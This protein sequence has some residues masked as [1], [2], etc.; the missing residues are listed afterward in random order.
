MHP[1]G[2]AAGPPAVPRR[3]HGMK[4]DTGT[5]AT[6]DTVAPVPF[7]GSRPSAAGEDHRRHVTGA[8]YSL[9]TKDSSSG[10]PVSGYL[11][12]ELKARGS[13]QVIVVVRAATGTGAAASASEGRRLAGHFSSAPVARSSVLAAS[14][15]VVGAAL[16]VLPAPRGASGTVDRD[17]LAALRSDPQVV[18]VG[19]A[20]ALSPI[21]PP[22][23][24][25][26]RLDTARTWGIERL[27]VPALWDRGPHGAGGPRGA[28]RHGCRR[29]APGPRGG[30]AH[31]AEFDRMGRAVQPPRS[32]TTAT[33]TARTPRPR[34]R[35]GRSAA[36]TW[37]WRPGRGSRARS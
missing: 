23:V 31:F 5:G 16:P 17:G 3:W 27:G 10:G 1:D 22:R 34:S 2:A 25:A 13:A 12:Q 9:G 4:T 32:R 7:R 18:S 28:P 15:G 35:A 36:A 11:T 20:P 29:Q 14:L 19:G 21:R 8:H 24:A 26:A 33:S 37:A 30:V 6:S